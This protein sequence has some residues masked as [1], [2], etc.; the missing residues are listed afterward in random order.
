MNIQGFSERVIELAERMSDVADAAA[1][2]KRRSPSAFTRL[3]VLPA[4]GAGLYALAKSDSFGQ[5]AK[6][7]VE[8]AK[9]LGSDLSDD[10]VNSVRQA[11][12]SP[13]KS[14][15]TGAASSTTGAQRR[16]SRRGQ[17]RKR[18][19]SAGKRETSS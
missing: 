15:S 5:Q 18:A 17:Q 1:G 6:V 11:S 10:L 12:Q 2:K 14:S 13:R 3:V 16:T 9:A 19:T 8:E 4:T 7:V